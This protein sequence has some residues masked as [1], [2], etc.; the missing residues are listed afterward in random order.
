MKT[1]NNDNGQNVCHSASLIGVIVTDIFPI[2]SLLRMPVLQNL[3][4]L[5]AVRIR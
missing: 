3:T 1:H 4:V 5:C 2:M